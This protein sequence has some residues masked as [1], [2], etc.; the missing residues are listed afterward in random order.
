MTNKAR[1][2]RVMLKADAR[3]TLSQP[4]ATDQ[5]LIRTKHGYKIILLGCLYSQQQYRP[6]LKPHFNTCFVIL[7]SILKPLT[8]LP[9]KGLERIQNTTFKIVN[10]YFVTK[11]LTAVFY[12]KIS[13]FLIPYNIAANIVF[14]LISN[15]FWY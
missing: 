1:A 15:S 2:I 14:V 5:F 11:L 4:L 7:N 10:T 13:T 3:K 6:G 8:D 12:P 9:I